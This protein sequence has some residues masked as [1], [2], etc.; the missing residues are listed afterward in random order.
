MYYEYYPLWRTFLERLGCE[1]V[2][3]RATT[4]ALV[5]AGSQLAVDEACLPVKLALGHVADLVGTCDALFVPRLITLGPRRFLCPK[6]VGFPDMVRALPLRCPALVSPTVDLAADARPE[7]PFLDAAR[8]LGKGTAAASA[9]FAAACAAQ[10]DFERAVRAGTPVRLALEEFERKGH[11]S[12]FASA[13]RRE[14]G[15]Q[16]GGGERLRLALLGHPYNIHDPYLSMDIALRLE[17][18][19]CEVLAL[20][21]VP[22]GPVERAVDSLGWNV[23]WAFGRR[24]LGSVVHFMDGSLDRDQPRVDGLVYVVSFGCGPDALLKG[25]VDLWAKRRPDLPYMPVVL[26]EHSA[27]TGLLTRLEAFVDMV[28]RV[29]EGSRARGLLRPERRGPEGRRT[30]VSFPHAGIVHIP[31]RAMVEDLGFDALV[32]P[33]NTRAALD[34]GA[35]HSPEL[36]CIPFKLMLGNYVEALERGATHLLGFGSRFGAS[37]RLYFFSPVH[38]E[39][40]RDMG[41]AFEMVSLDAGRRD[42]GNEIVRLVRSRVGRSFWDF[43]RLFFA[44]FMRKLLACEKVERLA[45]QTRPYELRRG[46]STR[47]A[48]RALQAI[49]RAEPRT[50]RRLMREIEEEFRAIPAD[51]SRRPLRVGVIGELYV[52]LDPFANHNIEERLGELGALVTRN[53]WT[54]KKILRTIWRRLDPEYHR[55]MRA[56]EEFL[57]VD[58]G[59]E[60]NVTVGDTV[61]YAREGLDGV[62]H[63]MPFT[64]MPEIV[65]ESVLPRARAASGMPT[66]TFALDEQTSDAGLQTRLEA[67]VDLLS[68]S[69]RRRRAGERA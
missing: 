36:A 33:E 4:R 23:Y 44:T 32:P 15:P 50:L 12:A 59:A 5:E 49:D 7:R 19:G 27:E 21:A 13:L 48:R 39:L 8:S 18:L 35:K 56:S 69:S 6:L 37:C 17:A 26:D 51:R 41:Y 30:L 64:C 16:D 14:A 22:E 9:A 57:G 2:A 40:L 52:L 53:F 61:N 54:S 10:R 55:A 28:R 20:E 11:A 46:D 60:C 25:V 67:F 1:V 43:A 66:V 47:L 42:S 65:A 58:I 63:L 38:E 29:R 68:R 24:V 31:L 62:V 34:I 45:M 3:S